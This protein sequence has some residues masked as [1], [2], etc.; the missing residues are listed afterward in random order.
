MSAT[1]QL[2]EQ[3][4]PAAGPAEN[5]DID[6]INLGSSDTDEL[7]PS[8][9]PITAQ[10]DGHSYEKWVRIYVPDLGGSS[11]VDNLKVWLSSL[12]GG[13]ATGE[14]ISTNLRESGY[15]T[16]TYPTAGPVQTD[17]P[18]ADQA[19]PESEPSGPNLGIGTSLAGQITT[20]PAYSDWLV[21]QLD[22][23]GSTPAGS[24]NQKTFTLQYDEM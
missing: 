16:K 11:I 10:A 17:S 20:A 5:L 9:Y 4:G 13:W 21:L 23:T 2:A 8:S 22:V 1:V 15:A 3:N 18:D 14:G 19:M 24:L 7:T 12:G 6:N